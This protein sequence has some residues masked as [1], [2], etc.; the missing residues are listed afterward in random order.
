MQFGQVSW[1]AMILAIAAYG[2]AAA[3]PEAAFSQEI[4]QPGLPQGPSETPLDLE[5]AL[6]WTLAHNPDLVA[7]RQNLSVSSAAVGVARKFPT[8]L[9]PTVSV[10]ARPWTFDRNMGQGARPLETDFTV[11]WAQPIELGGRTALR[12]EI[13]QASFSQTQWNNLQAE[14]MALVQ[15]YRLHQTA[16]YRREKLRVTQQLAEFNAQLVQAVRH[17][18]EAA[19][20][21]SADLVLAEVE[22][23]SM[24]QRLQTSRQEYLDALTE[25]RKQLGLPQY[26]DSVI[27]VG[28]LEVPEGVSPADEEDLIRIALEVHPE[29][30]AAR[31]Q[32]ANSR[33]ALFLARADRIP[34]PSIGPTYEHD[35]AGVT[36]YGFVLSTPVPMLNAG[37]TLVNQREIELCRDKVAVEQLRIRTV[38]WVKASLVKWNQTHDLVAKVDASTETIQAQ[39]EKMERLYSAGQTDLVKVFQVRQRLIEAKNAR[40]DIVWQATQAYADLLSAT[41]ATSL[42]GSLSVEP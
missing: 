3:P 22:N 34:I 42:L 11:S 20:A 10:D 26:A 35:E 39:V 30:N 40:L 18:V 7:L 1:V 36:Y 24:I 12:T 9:N 21:V 8:S 41:G 33:A 32:A 27:P 4:V 15:T 28:A 25:L 38:A 2:T 29:I 14:L 16:T 31:S 37:R 23:Q 13:A 17:Q 5:T 19:Q 6:Q